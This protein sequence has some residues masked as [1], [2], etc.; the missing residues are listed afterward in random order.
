MLNQP[1]LSQTDIKQFLGSV[2]P[3]NFQSKS[4][5][6]RNEW[7]Q[8][9]LIHYRYF[10]LFKPAKT[11]LRKF[12]R[13]MT[14]LSKSQLT[15][16]IAEYKRR[17]TLKIKDYQRHRFTKIYGLKEI[18]LLSAVDDAHN[19]LSGP[20]TKR[21]IQEDYELFGCEEYGKLKD[22]SVAHLYR[23]RATRRYREITRFFEKT[24]PTKVPIGERRK[25]EPNGQPGYLCVDSVHQGD[26]DGQKGVYHVNLVD[27]ATQFEFIGAVEAIS[28]RFMTGMLK[29]LIE[30][31]PF[32]ILEFH[33]DNGSE[34]INQVIA[35]LLNNLLIKLTKSRPR[36]SNDNPLVET[37]NGAVIRKYIG[38][39]Y[40]PRNKAIIVN[41]FYQ[42]Y[43]NDYLNYHRMCAFPEIKIDAKG[44]EKKFYPLDKYLTPY[45]K[46][47]TIKDAMLYL[48][49]GVFFEQLDKKAYA[50]S[51]TAAGQEMQKEKIKML[52][53]IFQ[54]Q[55]LPIKD[56]LS[57]SGV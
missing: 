19:C 57:N 52:K 25:P 49:P 21:I 18:E 11:L 28:E 44:K 13:K 24:R 53:S 45:A 35:K 36:H 15:R 26:R 54:Q 40:I 1:V 20:A 55:V 10:N 14:G 7:L 51:H 48:K 46:L 37:K 32:V 3:F 22:L 17:G 33:A 12:I 41:N 6:E 38:Y 8:Q 30:K 4:V 29:E 34:Y 56:N 5:A 16:L 27:M 50:Q 2:E 43:F 39:Q 42:E 47:K 23:L 31:F 9:I